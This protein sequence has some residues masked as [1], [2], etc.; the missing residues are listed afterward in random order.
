METMTC[1][2]CMRSMPDASQ[3]QTQGAHTAAVFVLAAHT[4]RSRDIQEIH[5]W[6]Q[7]QFR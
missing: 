6:K 5:R 7:T 2:Y 1:K 3:P 4:G